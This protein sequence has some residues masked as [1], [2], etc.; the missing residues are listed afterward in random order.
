LVLSR[1]G[2]HSTLIEFLQPIRGGAVTAT[3]DGRSAAAKLAVFPLAAAGLL[4]LGEML[5]PTGLDKPTT[6]APAALRALSIAAAHSSRLYASNLLVIFGLAALGV[7]FAA[8]ATLTRNREATLGSAAAVIGGFA[9]F[10][11]ALANLLV[12]FNVAA[13]A[14]AHTTATAAAQVLV[15]A[16]TSAV[17]TMLLIGYLGGGLVAILLLG[18]ALWRSRTVPRWLP[19]LFGFGLVVAAASRPGAVAIPLQ[20]P[21]AAAMILL[22]SRILRRRPGV[23]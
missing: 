19:V 1:H 3:V 22:A 11:G 9:A 10:C 4:M 5:T 15:S 13:A 20:L 21:F 17:S 2:P 14:T 6:T 23:R 12:G 16:D 18:T 8:I 7:S